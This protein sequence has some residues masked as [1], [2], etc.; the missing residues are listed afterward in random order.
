MLDSL[1]VFRKKSQCCLSFTVE[2]QFFLS[3]RVGKAVYSS[4]IL[5]ELPLCTVYF[6][7]QVTS[8]ISDFP[9]SFNIL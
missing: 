9:V 5:N 7:T 1:E 3:V 2:A 4:D 6:L 8:I